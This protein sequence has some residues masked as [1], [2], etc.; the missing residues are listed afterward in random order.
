MLKR[1]RKMIRE[2]K[3]QTML[4]RQ[5]YDAFLGFQS[6]KRMKLLVSCDNIDG[7]RDFSNVAKI[8]QIKIQ[9]FISGNYVLFYLHQLIKLE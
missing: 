5:K 6:N 3:L 7:L 8:G 1:V 9:W 2:Q 4:L